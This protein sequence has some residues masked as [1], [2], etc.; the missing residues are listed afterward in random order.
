VDTNR[1]IALESRQLSFQL[2]PIQ[3]RATP[4]FVASTL[5]AALKLSR[6]LQLQIN[7]IGFE[8]ALTAF[9]SPLLEAASRTPDS[10]SYDDNRTCNRN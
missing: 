8:L 5:N 10:L 6:E 2:L 3:Q 7:E 4:E 9:D 1:G